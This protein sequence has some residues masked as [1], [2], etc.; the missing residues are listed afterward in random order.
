MLTGFL[1]CQSW[2]LF[3]W[4]IEMIETVTVK[5]SLYGVDQTLVVGSVQY[6]KGRWSLI[7]YP[8]HQQFPAMCHENWEAGTD[9]W[10]ISGELPDPA[11]PTE[12]LAYYIRASLAG[13]KARARDR[14]AGIVR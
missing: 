1:V 11:A 9:E 4:R 2:H 3:N 10:F 5:R 7:H 8:E 6:D 12:L 14:K 13:H